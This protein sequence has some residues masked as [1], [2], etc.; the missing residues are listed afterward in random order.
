MQVTLN[1]VV[2][3][4]TNILI[5]E[6]QDRISGR[7]KSKVL[8]HIL[9]YMLSMEQIGYKELILFG[10]KSTLSGAYLN[11]LGACKDSYCMQTE[12]ISFHFYNINGAEIAEGSALHKKIKHWYSVEDK[13]ISESLE[14]TKLGLSDISVWSAVKKYGWIPTSPQLT[15]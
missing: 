5:L 7:V 3:M 12:L 4:T 6:A 11:S 9:V 13:V 8:E 1:A 15:V 10:H 14:K 2:K